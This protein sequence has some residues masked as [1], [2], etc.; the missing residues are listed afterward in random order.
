MNDVCAKSSDIQNVADEEW[1]S[2]I[3]EAKEVQK[4]LK[5]VVDI[6]GK[7]FN[8]IIMKL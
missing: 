5:K 3:S 4:T 6:S 2:L 1:H 7:T 8:L